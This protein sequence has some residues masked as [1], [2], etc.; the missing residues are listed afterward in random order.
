M[1]RRGG[2]KMGKS[3]KPA[4]RRKRALTVS[5]DEM[6]IKCESMFIA[7]PVQG[8][9]VSNYWYWTQP[10]WNSANLM[11][12]TKNQNFLYNCLQYDRWRI[13]SVTIKVIPRGNVLDAAAAQR[14]ADYVF[15][16]DALVHTVLDRDG[17]GPQNAGQLS[18]YSSYKSYSALKT[19]SRTYAVKYPKDVWFDCQSLTSADGENMRRNLGLQG[20]ITL[21]AENF[22]EDNYEF[23]NEPWATVKLT[24]NVSFQGRTGNNM[25]VAVDASGQ[26][27]EAVI[28]PLAYNNDKPVC[29]PRGIKGTIHDTIYENTTGADPLEDLSGAGVPL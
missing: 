24:Y 3:K 2:K 26:P 23:Y 18:R 14:D 4:M 1:A 8:V 9:T 7:V 25:T 20:T 17:N 28:R 27:L 29:V 15:T 16:G 10:I 19:F 21:Y 5:R 11:D 6:N 22:I 13:H 12:V